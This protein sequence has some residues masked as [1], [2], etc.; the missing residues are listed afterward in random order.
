[1]ANQVITVPVFAKAALAILENQLGWVKKLYRA[2][3][4]EF[5]ETVNGYQKGGT[6]SIRRPTDPLV[7]VGAVASP[8][9][10]VEG[11]VS[12]TVDTQV[13]HDFKFSSVE[14][15]LDINDLSE[16]VIKPAMSNIANYIAADC[17]AAMYRGAYNWVGTPGQLVNSFADFAKAPERLDEMAA[18]QDDRYAILSPADHW[19]M[20]G[21][22]TQ[23]YNTGTE[24]SAYRNGSLGMIGGVDTYMSQLT[25]THTVGPLGGTPLVNGASQNVAYTAAKDT[26]TQSLITDGWTA[27]AANRLKAG[28]TFLLYAAGTSGA[29]VMM[30]NAKTKAV[31]DIPQM[32]TVVSDV[33]S[34]G[35]GNATL[36]IS[37]PI[38][39]SGPHQTVNVAPADNAGLTVTGTAA[40]GYRQNMVFHKNAMALACVPLESPQGAV[41]VSRETYKG[42][43]CRVIPYYDGTNDISNWRLDIL[44]GK[45]LIDPRLITR[46]S[47]TA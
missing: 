33:N 5:T 11:K 32:F 18:P 35:S 46:L 20:L 34:D 37:P 19:A 40:T 38:I 10:V 28:D 44:Y 25:P 41:N 27:A 1:M 23:L 17:A 3:E 4:S 24:G 26:W 39:T 16:R 36:T 13:G 43:S 7:R 22:Q 12:M 6:I 47:G 29:R 8:Q 15:T 14:L 21:S 2:H 42:F 30:V 31:T 45:K 9:D